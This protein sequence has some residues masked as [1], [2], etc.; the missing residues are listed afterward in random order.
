MGYI[1]DAFRDSVDTA[2][3]FAITGLLA[4]KE[5]ATFSETREAY[6]SVRL[7]IKEARRRSREDW[8]DSGYQTPH[9]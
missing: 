6:R 7:S 4:I 8:V 9:P 3:C 1:K 5:G 2:T